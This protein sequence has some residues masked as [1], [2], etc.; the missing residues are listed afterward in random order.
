MRHVAQKQDLVRPRGD[1]ATSPTVV[2]NERRLTA[3]YLLTVADIRGTSPKVWNAWKGKLLEDL[4]RADAARARRRAPERSTPR[5]RRR[6]DE[7]RLLLNLRDRC[8]ARSR[9]RC[10]R[11]L[12]AQLLRAPRRER[13]RLA[14]ALAVSTTSRPRSRSCARAVAARRRPAGAASTRPTSRD[15]FA[16]ICGYFDSAGFTIL[17]AKVHTT[18]HGY[19]LDTF[20]V[21]SRLPR[22]ARY[23][24]LISLRRDAARARARGDRAAARAEPRAASRGACARSRSRRA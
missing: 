15:L 9:R 21:V 16:R 19:A 20:L 7:A 6:K 2:G 24:D 5:S 22:A 8:P 3:L 14:H 11:T 13:D 4:Y 18:T 1:R 23:R 10:G 17:D 12:D